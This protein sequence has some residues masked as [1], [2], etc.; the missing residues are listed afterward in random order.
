MKKT[1]FVIGGSEVLLSGLSFP[2]YKVTTVPA[3]AFIPDSVDSTDTG[4]L[5][6]QIGHDTIPLCNQPKVY[7][8]PEAQLIVGL[9]DVGPP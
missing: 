6:L 8:W 3:Y 2:T 9:E 1:S 4:S 7:F 5:R